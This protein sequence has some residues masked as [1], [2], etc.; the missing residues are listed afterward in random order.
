MD[1]RAHNAWASL[2]G[3]S[4]LLAFSLVSYLADGIWAPLASF[5]V[6]GAIWMVL[7]LRGMGRERQRVS[8]DG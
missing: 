2:I 7:G 8:G 5:G 1:E 3:G 4:V 6:L